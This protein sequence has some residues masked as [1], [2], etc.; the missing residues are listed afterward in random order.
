M[1]GVG[2]LLSTLLA[3]GLACTAGADVTPMTP[4]A[5]IDTAVTTVVPVTSHSA[6][7]VPSPEA[8]SRPT[9]LPPNNPTA[10]PILTD[11]PVPTPDLEATV[12]V[13]VDERL[14][15]LPS[16]GETSDSQTPTPESVAIS[17]TAI[18]HAPSPTFT[19]IPHPTPTPTTA[20]VLT[21]T[22]APTSTP[23][24]PTPDPPAA[25]AILSDLSFELAATVGV[26]TALPNVRVVSSDLGDSLFEATVDWG[27]GGE[28]FPVT[29]IQVTGQILASHTYAAIGTYEL[30]VEVSSELGTTSTRTYS[31]IVNPVVPTP[32]PT[33]VLA[34]VI[35]TV[36]WDGG[37]EIGNSRIYELTASE[38]PIADVD[39]DGELTDDIEITTT[40]PS[41][42]L[43]IA[44]AIAGNQSK[45][46]TVTIVN[47]GGAVPGVTEA[48]LEFS[49]VVVP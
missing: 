28:P 27:D 9:A 12:Q 6:V 32:T 4:Q 7:N 48:R 2:W 34:A 37:T 40:D 33:P 35:K 46:G 45:A 17:A 21:P 31:V 13:L 3:F 30:I 19:P 24:E 47:V 23:L 20:E 39:G 18:I 25:L 29:V 10:A 42:S 22:P 15:A 44:L 26:E 8:Q 14:A 49:R 1:S 43:Q 5:E 11:T 38:F 41:G 16:I 36:I